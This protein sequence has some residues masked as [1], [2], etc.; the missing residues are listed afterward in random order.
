MAVVLQFKYKVVRWGLLA[1][2]ILYV[3]GPV[4]FVVYY[5]IASYFSS[6]EYEDRINKINENDTCEFDVNN[7]KLT[8]NNSIVRISRLSKIEKIQALKVHGCEINFKRIHKRY[9]N[10]E[11]ISIEN[12]YF[13]TKYKNLSNI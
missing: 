8:L 1:L 11:Q 5:I 3:L 2:C 10:T 6:K 9:P 13:V 12:G 4:L 7:N